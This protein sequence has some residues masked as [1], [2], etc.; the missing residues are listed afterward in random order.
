[1]CLTFFRFICPS[2]DSIY[3]FL[4]FIRFKKIL[5][6]LNRI[7]NFLRAGCESIFISRK[8]DRS[9]HPV[10][11]YSLLRLLKYL[12]TGSIMGERIPYF[13]ML[14]MGKLPDTFN[15]SNSLR[16]LSLFAIPL[17][18]SLAETKKKWVDMALQPNFDVA[19]RTNDGSPSCWN[20]SIRP[21]W[22]FVWNQFL[23]YT[24]GLWGNMC[25][26][27]ECQLKYQQNGK[28]TEEK[29]YWKKCRSSTYQAIWQLESQQI[30]RTQ[31]FS[32]SF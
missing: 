21:T 8:R 26:W 10:C 1:M 19:C 23:R 15:S 13:K 2:D 7:W 17:S 31:F 4:S 6:D 9:A 32:S 18:T 14:Y 12:G 22:E 30:Q 3:Y 29:Y 25:R 27:H 20:P 24:Q 16:L 28:K 11:L 5:N